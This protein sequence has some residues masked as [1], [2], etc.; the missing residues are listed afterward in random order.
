VAGRGARKNA[1]MFE[2]SKHRFLL[3]LLIF[4]AGNLPEGQQ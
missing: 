3:K 2:G 1:R 4:T